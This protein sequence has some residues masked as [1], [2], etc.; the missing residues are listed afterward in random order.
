[1]KLLLNQKFTLEIPRDNEEV[2]IITGTLLPLSKE[3]KREIKEIVSAE[4]K[5]ANDLNKSSVALNRYIIKV[6]KAE[7]E[8]SDTLDK[9]YETLDKMTSDI[10]TQRDNLSDIEIGEVTAKKRFYFSV[11]SDKHERLVEICE[12]VGYLKVMETI[13]KDIEEGKL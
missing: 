8:E 9:M 6:Q 2:E 7:K 3:Q 11:K 4:N 1:M 10:D 12:L 13:F 5:K